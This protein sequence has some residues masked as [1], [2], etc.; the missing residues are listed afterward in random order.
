MNTIL[1]SAASAAAAALL[2]ATAAAGPTITPG[3]YTVVTKS[4][5]QSSL[6]TEESC[7]SPAQAARGGI[8]VDTPGSC[9][10][11]RDVRAG[12]KLDMVADCGRGAGMSVAGSYTPTSF[13]Y[14]LTTR[15]G[16]LGNVTA[17]VK[18]QKTAGSCEA[19]DE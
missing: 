5:L 11:V 4:S 13:D 1:F 16:P 6:I 9:R 10:W 17:R 7:V 12:G 14:V 8:G 2:G 19:D 18:G 15:G 3:L